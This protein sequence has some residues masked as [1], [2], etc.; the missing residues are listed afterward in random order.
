M[1]YGP[2]LS[3]LHPLRVRTRTVRYRRDRAAGGEI[4][5]NS[6]LDNQQVKRRID[7]QLL[8]YLQSTNNSETQEHLNRLLEKARPIVYRIARSVRTG[9]DQAVAS[10]STQDIFGDVCVQLIQNLRA[11]KNDPRQHPIS[12]FSGLVAATTSGVFAD[13]MRGRDRQRRSLY[14]KI[15]RLITANPELATWKDDN[16]ALVCGYAVWR[17][18]NVNPA[19]VPAQM[20]LEFQWDQCEQQ[21]KRNT[22]ELILLVLNNVGRPIKFD[23]FVDLVNIASAG[24]QVQT[25]NIDDEHFVQS[26]PLVAY[27]PDFVGGLENQ[28]LL[29]RLIAEIGTLRVEQRKSLLLNMTDSHGFGIE[30]FLFTKI[31]SEEHLAKLLEVSIEQ[32]RRMLN[33]LPMSDAQIAQELGLDTLQV[34]NIRRAVRERLER[35]RRAF[36]GEGSSDSVRLK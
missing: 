20:K 19:P 14:Q 7:E 29:N 9:A 28:R 22:A 30:W 31:A 3:L 21:Y 26:S 5:V 17:S 15:R 35:R 8:P 36:L 32:F 10:F 33:D 18:A 12:N 1:S 6:S 13:F 16:G 24:V 34:R 2:G 23:E 25:I 4:A 11:C 27:Q